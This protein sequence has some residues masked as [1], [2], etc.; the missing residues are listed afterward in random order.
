LPGAAGAALETRTATGGASAAIGTAATAVGTA[1]AAIRASATAIASTV[2]STA[3]EWPLEARAR[4]A[5]DAGGVAREIFTR[6]ARAPH[7]RAT[8]FAGEQ[9][10]VVFDGRRAFHKGFAG[11]CRDRF[12]FDM[13]DLGVLVLGVLDM[14]VLAMRCVVLGVLLSHVRS[15]FRTV[16]RAPSFDFLDFFLREFRNFSD[17]CFF[18]FFCFFFVE[19]G[20]ADDGI[21]FRFFLGLFVFGLDKTG[22]ERG[23]LIFVQ[24]KVIASR[25]GFI[26]SRFGRRPG[27]CV[28]SGG[29]SFRRPRRFSR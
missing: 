20:A 7:A 1:T 21:G 13:P 15:E 26:F 11:G 5:A 8:S 25:F 9:N 10:H 18:T 24:F 16:G 12:L 3:A 27:D 29:R 17:W 19:F 22:S 2:T 6:R 28:A 14:F 23:D 4:V